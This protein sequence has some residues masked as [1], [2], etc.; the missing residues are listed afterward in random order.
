M[1]KGYD[2]GAWRA[3]KVDLDTVA[4]VVGTAGA[5]E[6]QKVLHERERRDHARSLQQ[7]HNDC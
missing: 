5:S 7:K 4:L 2:N 3:I 6:K 1:V